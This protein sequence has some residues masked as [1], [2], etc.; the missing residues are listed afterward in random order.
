MPDF[1]DYYDPGILSEIEAFC[2]FH[3]N[4]IQVRKDYQELLHLILIFIGRDRFPIKPPGAISNAR[5]LAK[6]IYAIKKIL[7]R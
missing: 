5:W 7:F 3:L 2:R 1:I 4:E 6:G